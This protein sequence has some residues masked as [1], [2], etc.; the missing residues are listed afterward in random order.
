MSLQK[1]LIETIK[2]SN[3]F[4]HKQTIKIQG[5]YW[6][7]EEE[8]RWKLEHIWGWHDFLVQKKA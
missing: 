3:T 8:K 6:K 4:L 2:L 5:M 7:G 1:P